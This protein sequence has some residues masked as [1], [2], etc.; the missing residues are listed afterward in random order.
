MLQ[1]PNLRKYVLPVLALTTVL[2]Y[3]IPLFRSQTTIHWDLADVT[4]PAQKFFAESI[5][6]GKLP[7]WTPYLDSGIPFLADPRT[8][9]WYPLHWPFFLIGMTHVG[10]TP[11][12]LVWELVLHA[13][14]ALVGAYLLA[15]KLFSA[16]GP[17][18]VGALLFGFGGFFAAHTSTLGQFEAASLFPLLLW[19]TLVALESGSVRRIACAGLVGGLI[20][21]TGDEWSSA[22]SLLAL[23]FLAA[24]SA[25]TSKV[26][27]KRALAVVAPAT[28]LAIVLGGIVLLPAIELHSQSHP[29]SS[30]GV[31]HFGP[32]ATLVAADYYGLISS[33]YSGSGD[34]R[35]NYLYGGLLL[36]PLVIAGFARREKILLLSAMI[37]PTVVFDLARRPPGDAWFPAALGLAMAASSG[38]AWLAERTERPYIWVALALLSVVDLW[39][40]NLYKNPL[41][42]A[43]ATFSEVYGEMKPNQS[44]PG[45]PERPFARTWAPFVPVGSGPADGSLISHT[46]VT[47][48]EGLAELDRYEAYLKDVENNPKLL[49]GLGVT[50]L[51]LGRNRRLSNPGNLGR[52]S[53]PPSVRFVA[54]RNAAV[55]A[56]A[57]LDPGQ[58]AVV[59]GAA[60]VVAPSVQSIE[61]TAYTGDSYHIRYMAS[62]DS[63]LRIAVPF[64]PGWTAQVDGRGASLVPV[65]EALMG[66]FVPSGSHEVTL[67]FR[68]TWFR[69]GVGLTLVAAIALA[70]GLIL[71]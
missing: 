15:R 23:V 18:V 52:V 19:A 70:I 17:S 61:I 33:L 62:S 35:Q 9:A 2:F 68:S 58:A 26:S 24:A 59:E 14:L 71:S 39:F 16:R 11:G 30:G 28:I 66:V 21:L 45:E 49:N 13:F 12:T 63:L 7:Q 41:V 43:H 8:G 34:P 54:D 4:Y 20:V 50:D 22:E 53:T 1:L 27:W 56:L 25:A 64:Y 47:Y 37:L 44:L 67:E 65:D 51:I 5:S 36:L 6:A 10:I 3:S 60:S 38:T 42:F 55:G 57:T 48:G 29:A 32:L 40:W 31:F 69:T 46:E